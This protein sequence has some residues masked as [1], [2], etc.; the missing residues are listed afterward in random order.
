V[1]P[2]NMSYNDL[3]Q[4]GI[5]DL[6][7][8]ADDNKWAQREILATEHKFEVPFGDHELSGIVD[9]LEI[10]G[11][12]ARKELRVVDYKTSSRLPTFEQLRFNCQ[13]SIYMLATEQPEFWVNIPNG[14][15]LFEDLVGVPRRG[16]WYS[17]WHHKARDVGPRHDEDYMRLYRVMQE[18]EKAVEA[19]VYVPNI[20]AD[21]CMFC[22]YTRLCAV[23]IPIAD[24][25]EARRDAR[26]RR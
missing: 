14:E 9:V 24:E 17:L 25:I 6:R 10:H 16:I 2:P 21:G 20:S 7:R 19:D 18:I 1:W 5:E 13:F 15:K 3:R 12:G 11:K 22:P 4:R 26:F 8:Y 23:T